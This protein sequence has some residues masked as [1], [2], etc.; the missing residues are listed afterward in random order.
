MI[1][2]R[3]RGEAR[4]RRVEGA[5]YFDVTIALSYFLYPP[6]I[7]NDYYCH[8]EFVASTSFISRTNTPMKKGSVSERSNYYKSNKFLL[9]MNY[10]RRM[11]IQ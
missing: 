1:R 5:L 8:R 9:F 4:T 6:S 7:S 11:L 3:W 2:E 10:N